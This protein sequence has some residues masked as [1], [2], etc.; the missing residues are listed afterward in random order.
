MIRINSYCPPWVVLAGI[1]FRLHAA[2]TT[3]ACKVGRPVCSLNLQRT[4]HPAAHCWWWM[5]A[6][7]GD[8]DD[9]ANIFVPMF[10][11]AW[12]STDNP[13][14]KK[15]QGQKRSI[16]LIN[17]KTPKKACE[18]FTIFCICASHHQTKCKF[19]FQGALSTGADQNAKTMTLNTRVSLPE[20]V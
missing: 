5:V 2:P 9:C 6:T 10:R 14:Q 11:E 3:F 20:N 8:S 12:A 16:F 17:R 7:E 4:H 1:P 13:R 18:P 19:D 15:K